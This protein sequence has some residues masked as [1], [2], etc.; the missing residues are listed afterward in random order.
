VSLKLRRTILLALLSGGAC[1][2]ALANPGYPQKPIRLVVGFP[3]GG[4]ADNVAR[5]YAEGL[6]RVLGQ[7]VIVDNRPGAGTT[8]A[9]D[10]VAKSAPDGYT[11][12]LGSASL[13]GGDQALYKSLKYGP[14]DF[15]PVIQLTVSP[16]LLAV[17]K[18]S[19]ITSVAALVQKASASPN[20][21]NYASSGNGVITHLAGVEFS[22]LA[23]V[24]MTHV[25]YKGGAPATQAVASGDADV[26]FATASSVQPM[27]DAGRVVPLAVTTEKRFSL[28]PSYPSV[29]ESGVKG[30]NVSVW[31]GVFVPRSVP[32]DIQDKLF[33]ASQQVMRD[34]TIKSRLASRGEEAAPS[35]SQA[36]FKAF[37]A[38]EGKV[39]EALVLRSGAT[40]D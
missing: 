27:I 1:I 12:Y 32:Q 17:S 6:S 14:Q 38:A 7:Q 16:L 23:G 2:S 40:V 3:P 8:I 13:M 5:I 33:A 9:A 10:Y 30:F 15:S 22:R 29:A 35:K 20:A 28:L 34:P 24:K 36:E 18:K 26:I 25:P 21:I 11:L 37:A 39:A 19:G 31:Y 4:G